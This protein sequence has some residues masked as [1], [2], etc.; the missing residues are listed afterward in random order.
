[1]QQ[2]S[3]PIATITLLLEDIGEVFSIR[4]VEWLWNLV[5]TFSSKGFSILVV[6]LV[7][8]CVIVDEGGSVSASPYGVGCLD[9][10]SPEG[11]VCPGRYVVKGDAV[12][13]SDYIA[14]S[15]LIDDLLD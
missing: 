5:V 13:C 4:R 7:C 15:I 8:N 10:S 3:I 12:I 11:A 9:S 2:V 14:V 1:M 6:V